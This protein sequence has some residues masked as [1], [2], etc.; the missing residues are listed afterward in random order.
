MIP[1]EKKAELNS[2]KEK[3]NDFSKVFDAEEARKELLKLE[4]EMSGGEFWNNKDRAAEVLRDTKI[5][6]SQVNEIKKI[7]DTI[8]DAGVAL[9][10][11]EED[12]TMEEQFFEFLSKLKRE[13]RFFELSMLLNERFDVNNTFLTI[14]AGAGGTESQDWTQMLLRM[15]LRW[16]ERKN[17]STEIIETQPGEEAGIKSVTLLVKGEYT[18]GYLKHEQGIH[19]LVRIS[20]FDSNNRRHTSFA[21]VSILPELD[22][23]INL[24]IDPDDLRI[25]VYRSS[26]AGGQHVNRT[27]SAVRITHLPTKIVVTCQNQRNQHQNKDTAMKVLMARLYQVELKKQKAEATGIQG[28]LNDVSWGNQ[29]RSYVFH[30][31][32][33]VKDLRTNVETGNADAVMDGELDEFIEQELVYFSKKKRD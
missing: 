21:S 11:A 27:E 16:A 15:Y 12:E 18:Y 2:L 32:R 24:D 4:N 9:E 8:G 14:H 26:G 6:R 22:D 31:Y 17:F 10:F 5:I 28:E 1:Y 3:F 23:S 19:R 7:N 20:P 30:P 25:D 29:I 33:M 13:V